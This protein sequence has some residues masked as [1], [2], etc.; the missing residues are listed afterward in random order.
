MARL[1]SHA[2]PAIALALCFASTVVGAQH[3]RTRQQVIEK[4]V[5]EDW[6]NL[7]D[8]MKIT[9]DKAYLHHRG[10][11]VVAVWGIGFRGD[12]R[13]YTL[14]ECEKLVK[15][16]KHDTAY[17]KNTVMLGVPTGWRTLDRDAVNDP[18]FHRIIR[19]VDIISP[20]SVGRYRTPQQA[21][22]HATDVIQPDFQWANEHGL[23]HM[24]VIFPGGMLLE[25]D[26]EVK[27][28]YGA[29]DTV[30]CLSTGHVDDLV[31]A[32]LED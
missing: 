7:V 15:F 11:P 32:C 14:D 24:P 17:V 3:D 25:D 19:Q 1:N 30:E 21:Q 20:W 27:L 9:Q 29:S 18:Q 4:H 12:R 23:E 16:L 10:K 6:K 5:I 22:Q 28:Y 8:R 31:N 26:G 2:W 13:E